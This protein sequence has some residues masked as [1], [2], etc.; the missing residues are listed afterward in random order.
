MAERGNWREQED[1]KEKEGTD[2]ERKKEE[3]KSE[4]Q[5]DREGKI[6]IEIDR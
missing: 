6:E 3:R 5:K 4:R 1:Y 2:R